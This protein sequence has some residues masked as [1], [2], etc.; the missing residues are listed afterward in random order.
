MS[1][2][3]R[4]LSPD[5]IRKL[6]REIAENQGDELFAILSREPEEEL[7]SILCVVARGTRTEVP[8]LMSRAKPGDM[9]LHNHPSGNLQPSAADMNV[10]TLFGE[11]GIGSMI[12][13]NELNHCRVI[14]EPVR[15]S[16]P[17]VVDTIDVDRI[18]AGDGPLAQ[19]L[20]RYES[21]SGQVQMARAVAE[22]L[23][24]HRILA[25]EAG[26]GTGKSLAYLIPALLWTKHNKGRVVIATKTIA[27][28]EQ[29]MFKDIPVARRTMPNA[30]QASLVKGRNN[31][32][33]LRKLNDLKFNQLQLFAPEEGEIRKE[34]EDLE[35][36]V[37]ESGS[38]DRADLP[39]LPSKEAWEM[40]RSDADMCLG[41]KCP[42]FQKA[43]FYESRR[44]AAQSRI[45]VV[46]QALL[47]SDLAMRS[48]S[49]NYKA[50]AVIPPYDH[51][52]L[53][54]AHSIEDIAT[55][56]FGE[57]I[58]SFGLRLTLGRFLSTAR[59]NRGLLLRLF[60]AAVSHDLLDLVKLLEDRLLPEFRQLQDQVLNQLYGLSQ[61]LHQT[62]NRARKNQEVIWLKETLLQSGLLDEAR[63]EAKTLLGLLH[64][65][66]LNIRRIRAKANGEDDKFKENMSGLFI[67]ME[68]R[69]GRLEATM[70]ALKNFAIRLEPNQVPWLELRKSRQMD[71][72]EY[73][74]S[75][76]LVDGM[77][78]ETLFKP[79]KSVI[80]TSATLDLDD[81]FKFLS[82]RNGLEHFEDK[83]WSFL[84]FKSPFDYSRQAQLLLA[85]LPVG[86][87]QQG[88][89]EELR[90]LILEAVFSGHPGGTLVLFTSYSQLY[91]VAA[92]LE[93]PLASAG[94]ALLVQGR[95]SRSHLLERLKQ[96]QGVL[97]GT[98]SFWE[99]VDLPGSA[100]TKLI[101][102]KLPFR[103]LGDP[104]FEARC[105]ALEAAG[106][107]S[108]KELSLPIALLKF[109]QGAGRLIRTQQD[110]GVLIIA[111]NRIRNKPYGRRF[112]KLLPTFPLK[113]L[114]LQE[115]RRD[116]SQTAGLENDRIPG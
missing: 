35:T 30:P 10:A 60:Q 42:F 37:E 74:V 51:V 43:P 101:M 73:R 99:G 47:F 11:E 89:A 83:Q 81:G 34:I 20:E 13:D 80:M 92:L 67:E 69:Q 110:R 38:G 1:E 18:F 87:Q 28:Q 115:L 6:R 7:F 9:T 5:M 84:T 54:E 71:E 63:E 19:Q 50:A 104:I 106:K 21:R 114:S 4:Y 16:A 44:R 76:L 103:Q 75:P 95:S 77:L 97:L 41:S 15:D 78:R 52:I 56:H 58:S 64:Q 72:F 98:D 24:E 3:Q 66:V 68:A 113:E 105:A 57:K 26:T 65:L 23:N 17:V 108:F 111:D 91:Q 86:P 90:A 45:L 12:V 82:Q 96:T 27:L 25:A 40:V 31:Y 59:G 116:L 62:L 14:V 102:A 53:D 85:R 88:F 2:P 61:A 107:S 36:W 46:N 39:F 79:F 8:A 112:L 33:C 29:L 109:K 22:T 49:G 32:I 100:L 93:D 94:V 55:D 70:A 48:V